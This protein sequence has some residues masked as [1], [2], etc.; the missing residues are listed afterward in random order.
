[1]LDRLTI[2]RMEAA[3]R[4]GSILVAFSGGGDSTALLLLLAEHFGA[5]RLRA[6]IVD[7]ALRAGSA[8]D[9][10]RAVQFAES[11]GVEADLLTL[12]WAPQQKRSQ[13]TAREARHRTLYDVARRHGARVIA[14]GHTA[15]DQ[16]E[17]VLMRAAAGSAWRGLAGIAPLAPAPIWPEGRGLL[18]ARPVLAAR[19]QELRVFLKQRDAT[20]ID[21]PSNENTAYERVRVRARLSDLERTGLDVMALVRLANRMRAIANGVDYAAAELIERAAT[22]DEG[23]IL[24]GRDAWDAEAAVR[25]RALSVLICAASGESR[26]PAPDAVER[27][28]RRMRALDFRGATLGGA[29][30]SARGSR[31]VVMR[32][33]GALSGRAGG[34]EPLAPVALPVDAELVWDGRIALTASALGGMVY[35]DGSKPRIEAPRGGHVATHWLLA[36]RVAHL[37]ATAKLSGD[38]QNAANEINIPKP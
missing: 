21:D 10:K 13:E 35:A 36:S 25:E 14:L 4:G 6:A 2:E 24:I 19:R 23:A 32:D 26:A 17:T 7:H 20:W 38:P 12:A 9:A 16:A 33:T 3:A 5:S 30:L 29:E 22:F 18:L 11:H 37:L 27:L 15:D 8:D 34:R 1:M 28:A 31:L